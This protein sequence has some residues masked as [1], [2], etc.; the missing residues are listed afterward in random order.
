MCPK[1]QKVSVTYDPFNCI[2]LELPVQTKQRSI[3]IKFIRRL[4]SIR[5]K[6]SATRYTLEV[7][8][9]GTI[10]DL[11][12]KLSPLTG[13]P[14]DRMLVTDIYNHL[15]YQHFLYVLSIDL[16]RGST[17][18]MARC[19]VEINILWLKFVMTIT[20]WCMKFYLRR[21]SMD[22]YA[23]S[24]E[25][26]DRK[27]TIRFKGRHFSSRL[28]LDNPCAGEKGCRNNTCVSCG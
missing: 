2:Q 14:T 10:G 27:M 26:P 7:D 9:N 28:Y 1:C 24:I 4:S 20:S 12:A 13:L 22:M 19:T 18:L 11:L 23:W 15:M 21:K 25:N 16:D 6:T 5:K 3:T 8:K 17:Q